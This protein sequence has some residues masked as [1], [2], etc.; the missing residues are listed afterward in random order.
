M[1]DT[2]RPYWYECND[3]IVCQWCR[4]EMLRDWNPQAV[5]AKGGS[6]DE[7]VRR[8]DFRPLGRTPWAGGDE[9]D[10]YMQC[11]GCLG[12]WGPDA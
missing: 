11:D 12:Q 6:E 3:M 9:G 4:A 5:K 1:A 7:M 10:R 8:A 2:D